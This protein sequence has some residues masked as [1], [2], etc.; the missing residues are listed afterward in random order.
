MVAFDRQ[1]TSED[2]GVLAT[3]D[4]D[5]PLDLASGEEKHM[6][7]D[8]PGMMMRKMLIALLHEHGESEARLPG[9]TPARVAQKPQVS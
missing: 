1:V 4:W 5:A 6:P 7:S 3:T 8:Q 2:K 9:R